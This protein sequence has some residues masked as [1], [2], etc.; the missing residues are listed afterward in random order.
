MSTITDTEPRP[1][2]ADDP[3][4]SGVLA[5]FTS[6]TQL[7]SAVRDL[8]TAGWSRLEA[9]SPF[10]IHG[11]DEALGIRPTKLPWLVLGGALVGACC[12]FLMQHWM[13]GVDYPFLISGKPFFSI[14]SSVPVTFEV[15]ILLAAVAAF[16]GVPALNGLP[17][18]SNPILKADAFRSVSNDHFA[19][20]ADAT[21]RKFDAL[22]FRLTT[23]GNGATA[24]VPIDRDRS[25]AAFPGLLKS[26]TVVLSVLALIPPALIANARMSTSAKPRIHPIQDM[27]FQPKFKSQTTSP[28]FDD[29]RAMRPQVA[30]TVARG[31]LSNDPSD[32]PGYEGAGDVSTDRKWLERVPLEVDTSLI[33]R[34][35]ERFNIFCSACHGRG[36]DGDGIVTVRALELQQGTWVKP[37]PLHDQSVR[38]QPDGRLFATI[39]NGVRKMPG[40]ASQI[41]AEDRW[42]IVLYLRA[43]QKV[44]D[45]RIEE[46]PEAVRTTLRELN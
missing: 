8:R 42:A 19:L 25:P 38:S 41:A 44:R 36:G 26:A 45:G 6:E 23:N 14:P 2:T 10:P 43:L 3:A 33:E 18:L 31:D 11:I 7:L 28:H 21:D 17:A 34:G 15:A 22:K 32:V 40:Y 30:G 16:L 9:H 12:A 27:D 37:I 13:N 46:V 29:G 35:R 4:L 24:V 1:A 20:Y 39:T 5:V